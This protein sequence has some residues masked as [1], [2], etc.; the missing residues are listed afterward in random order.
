MLVALFTEPISAL[1]VVLLF[2]GLQQ[3]EGHVVAPQVFGHT[4]RI[5]PLLVIFALLFGLEVHGIIGALVALPI[6]SVLR[7]TAV[8]LRPPRHVRALGSRAS[9]SCCE[10]GAARRGA[11]QAL[12]RAWSRSQDVSF[13]LAAGELLAV[14]RA[15]RRGQDDAAVGDRRRAGAVERAPSAVPPREVGWAPAAD[16]ALREADGRREPRAV[17]TPRAR[18]RAA[19]PLS[20]RCSSRPA[21]PSA[22]ASSSARL[23]GGNRQRVNVAIGLI[24]DPPVLALDE[25]SAS[26]DPAQRERLWTFVKGLTATGRDGD[27]LDPQPGRGAAP[28]RPAARARRRAA[29]ASTARPASCSPAPAP[30]RATSSRPSSRS[31]SARAE[32][33][34]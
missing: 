10:R 9:A 31:S 14:A 15:E 17:R 25:P 16:G 6:L 1:W 22:P 4:L 26:L 2:I 18:R 32:A 33:A 23:S 29:R 7:E 5:N 21:W 19:A 12:R 8:Y 28:R 13:E 30:A 27:L 20:P 11:R 24:G 34:A 3:V